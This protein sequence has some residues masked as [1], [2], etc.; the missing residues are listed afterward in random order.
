MQQPGLHHAGQG[1]LR[2][3][4]QDLQDGPRVHEEC[5]LQECSAIFLMIYPHYVCQPYR[6]MNPNPLC[7][8]T[9]TDYVYRPYYRLHN[10]LQPLMPD[11]NTQVI[12]LS[13]IVLFLLAAIYYILKK[14]ERRDSESARTKTQKR[15]SFYGKGFRG[16]GQEALN[17]MGKLRKRIID[18]YYDESGSS[19]SESDEGRQ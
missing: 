1:G 16:K 2:D 17:P 9:D 14:C 8:P 11:F 13:V 15:S 12:L 19:S 4:V 6:F 10:I 5:P 7:M 18:Y 3:R